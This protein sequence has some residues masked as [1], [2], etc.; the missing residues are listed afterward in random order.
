[1]RHTPNPVPT[2]RVF[3]VASRPRCQPARRAH[4]RGTRTERPKFE[5]RHLSLSPSLPDRVYGTPLRFL[6]L[7]S[8]IH[9]GSRA[10]CHTARN[11][12]PPRPQA[13]IWLT[14]SIVLQMAGEPH[15]PRHIPNQLSQPRPP[16]QP[17]RTRRTYATRLRIS[18]RLVLLCSRTVPLRQHD[19]RCVPLAES[20]LADAVAAHWHRFEV[21][22]ARRHAVGRRTSLPRLGQRHAARAVTAA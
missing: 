10:S 14:P 11:R 13:P 5:R 2:R 3:A 22:V 9:V 18:H 8:Q 6:S 19:A 17:R 20:K 1:M 15:R 21:A 16:T 7:S 12:A 4:A